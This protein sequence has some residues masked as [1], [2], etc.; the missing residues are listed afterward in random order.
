MAAMKSVFICK[1]LTIACE[2][3]E[4][5]KLNLKIDFVLN[6]VSLYKKWDYSWSLGII[7]T[8]FCVVRICTNRNFA[9]NWIM[10]SH[11]IF[12][13]FFVPIIFFFLYSFLS[14]FQFMLII[15]FSFFSFCLNQYHT[16][17]NDKWR[18]NFDYYMQL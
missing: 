10:I 5:G 15:C 11:T 18:L 7:A 6:I 3:C 4:L 17:K 12:L 16:T 2:L 9:H 1:F 13:L 14:L 8:R